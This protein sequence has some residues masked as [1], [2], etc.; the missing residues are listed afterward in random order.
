MSIIYQLTRKFSSSVSVLLHSEVD[1]MQ[2]VCSIGSA[3]FSRNELYPFI[4]DRDS[5]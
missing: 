3:F 4:A 2:D 5:T 1:V